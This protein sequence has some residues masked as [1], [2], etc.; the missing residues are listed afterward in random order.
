MVYERGGR[1]APDQNK[2]QKR[3]GSEEAAKSESGKPNAEGRQK[4]GINSW[5]DR[6][7]SQ[8]VGVGEFPNIHTD[9]NTGIRGL[10]E[11]G[12]ATIS[13]SGKVER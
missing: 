10:E 13:S 4:G 9:P 8:I 6:A 7:N 5:R 2:R 3:K 12:V 1:R 11:E